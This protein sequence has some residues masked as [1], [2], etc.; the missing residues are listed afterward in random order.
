MPNNNNNNNNNVWIFKNY[1]IILWKRE[2]S[3]KLTLL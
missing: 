1:Y 3:I 2:Q